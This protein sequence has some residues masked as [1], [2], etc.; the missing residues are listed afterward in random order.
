MERSP[1]ESP[2]LHA[3]VVCR[4]QRAP[5]ACRAQ[6]VAS[7]SAAAI[8]ISPIL[9]RAWKGAGHRRVPRP[10]SQCSWG[11]A[12]HAGPRIASPRARA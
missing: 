9:G 5:R 7:I 10:K 8:L 4:R 2:A 3:E 1:F 6:T 12:T 11:F